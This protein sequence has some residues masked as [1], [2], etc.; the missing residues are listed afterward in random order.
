MCNLSGFERSLGLGVGVKSLHKS[1][2]LKEVLVGGSGSDVSL[3]LGAELGL[4]LVRV[5]DSGEISACQG[6]F[7]LSYHIVSA[8]FDGAESLFNASIHILA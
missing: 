7:D 5:N 8:G 4:N 6:L 2:I 1:L 3:S